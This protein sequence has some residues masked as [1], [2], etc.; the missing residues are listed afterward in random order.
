MLYTSLVLAVGF[1]VL[2]ANFIVLPGKERLA[3]LTWE[4]VLGQDNVDTQ[5]SNVFLTD[6]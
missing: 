3:W 2:E 6:K 4:L 5:I 1:S